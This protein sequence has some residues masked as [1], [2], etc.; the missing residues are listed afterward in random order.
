MVYV[1]ILGQ[2]LHAAGGLA[3]DTVAPPLLDEAVNTRDSPLY[4]GNTILFVIKFLC[5][6]KKEV[7]LLLMSYLSLTQNSHVLGIVLGIIFTTH[8]EITRQ[9][10]MLDKS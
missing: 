1:F 2:I 5:C 6:K 4:I 8:F 7:S 3:C 9:P 10:G